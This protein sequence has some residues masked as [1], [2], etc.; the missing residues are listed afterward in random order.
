MDS[1]N[2]SRNF[3]DLEDFLEKTLQTMK[4][5]QSKK[6]FEM[7]MSQFTSLAPEQAN[8]F[9]SSMGYSNNKNDYQKQMAM[10][11]AIRAL[12]EGTAPT[13]FSDPIVVDKT[14]K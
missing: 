1:L 7:S 12:Y 2:E 9:I 10:I 5:L 14:S 11:T 6:I 3:K 8:S 4:M 13:F